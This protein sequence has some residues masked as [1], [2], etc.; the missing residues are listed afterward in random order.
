MDQNKNDFL[1]NTSSKTSETNQI[2]APIR[3][4]ESSAVPVNGIASEEAM[5]FGPT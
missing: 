4:G 3:Q 2:A 1:Q 5:R